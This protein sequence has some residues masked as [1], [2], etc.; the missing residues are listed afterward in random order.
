VEDFVLPLTKT[1]QELDAGNAW[2]AD[3]N[4]RS[5]LPAPAAV[6]L[7]AD[8]YAES[9]ANVQQA[10]EV[11][12]VAIMTYSSHPYHH[13]RLLFNSHIHRPSHFAVLLSFCKKKKKL[14]VP[15][16][17]R[18][19][20]SHSQSILAIPLATHPGQSSNGLVPVCRNEIGWNLT[21]LGI[22]LSKKRSRWFF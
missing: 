17:R 22:A 13:Q 14:A 4:K 3:L 6:E 21:S 15:F 9:Q 18:Q 8:S 5:D 12:F 2:P 10:L 20:R 1:A 11:R 7:L 16:V 19:T